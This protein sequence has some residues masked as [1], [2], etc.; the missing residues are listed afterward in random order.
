MSTEIIPVVE[1]FFC[2]AKYKINLFNSNLPSAFSCPIALWFLARWFFAW[3]FLAQLTFKR[4]FTQQTFG[5]TSNLV[6]YSVTFQL[7][8]MLWNGH[9]YCICAW[10]KGNDPTTKSKQ[11][12]VHFL[13]YMKCHNCCHSKLST[14]YVSFLLCNHSLKLGLRVRAFKEKQQCQK[15]AECQG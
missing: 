4:F 12:L 9:G 14:K 11:Y 5:L 10:S 8:I 3:R 2:L 6:L 7:K 1:F 15:F 13:W